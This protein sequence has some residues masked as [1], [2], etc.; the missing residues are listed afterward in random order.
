MRENCCVGAM[1]LAC[2]IPVLPAGLAAEDAAAPKPPEV[3]APNAAAPDF[4]KL[5]GGLGTEDA[6]AREA[7]AKALL[8]ALQDPIAKLGKGFLPKLAANLN[9]EDAA[10]REAAAK[11]LAGMVENNRKGNEAAFNRAVEK[12]GSKDAKE[13]ENTQLALAARLT[14]QLADS[15][16]DKLLD[17]LAAPDAAVS[18][19][20]VKKLQELGLDAASELV[21]ALEDER[22][23]VRKAAADILKAMGPQA[24][25]V[26]GD[27]ALLLDNNDK[28]TRRLAANLLE[29]LGPDAAEAAQDVMLYLENEDKSVRHAAASILKKMGPAIKE[30]APDLADLLS[31]ENKDVRALAQ[32]VLAN[33]GREALAVVA[34][35]G[36]M[37]DAPD[38]ND[39]DTRERAAA[40]LGAIG[41][42]AK[43][44]LEILKKRQKDKDASQAVKD[45]ITEAI[46]KIEAK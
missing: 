14:Q 11:T 39:A 3:A 40:I 45:A 7:A 46:K 10:T 25:E 6:K 26:A 16:I 8:K 2:L 5:L 15:V 21:S 13:R 36:E 19:A 41:P 17:D 24:K 9:S 1:F 4:A 32:G 30:M 37:L 28:G 22:P 12:C 29:N 43:G 20:A 33:L 23:A 42:D 31:N 18:G 34:P 27:L 38:D 44:A 35:L